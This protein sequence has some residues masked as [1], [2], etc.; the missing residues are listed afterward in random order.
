MPLRRIATLACILGLLL[1]MAGPH[2]AAYGWHD[3]GVIGG[4]CGRWRAH[5]VGTVAII[6]VLACS[7]WQPR[8]NG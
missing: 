1:A 2:C 3:L 7:L 6:A 8:G 5:P 4:V